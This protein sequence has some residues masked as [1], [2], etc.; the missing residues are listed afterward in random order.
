[1]IFRR[2]VNVRFL[3]E[4]RG[5]SEL[6]GGSRSR[7]TLRRSQNHRAHCLERRDP[8]DVKEY[9]ERF[10]TWGVPIDHC[11]NHAYEEMDNTVS[12]YFLDPEGE[13]R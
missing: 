1:M 9:Y 3:S 5:R 11:V 2:L 6:V 12:C 7:S 13:L 10:K 4:A 8:I